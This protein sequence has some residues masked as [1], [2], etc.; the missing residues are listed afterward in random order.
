MTEQEIIN[1]N[2]LIAK[3]MGATTLDETCRLSDPSLCLNMIHPINNDGLEYVSINALRYNSNW[4]WLMP[5]FDKLRSCQ[6]NYRI[7]EQGCM[8]FSWDSTFHME[9]YTETTIIAC[10]KVLIEFIKWFNKKNNDTRQT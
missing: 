10:F 6:C 3:F 5:C 8:I 2:I 1:G 4:S 9:C 7:S